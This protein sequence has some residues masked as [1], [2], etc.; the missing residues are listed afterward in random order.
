[1]ESRLVGASDHD[2]LTGKVRWWANGGGFM[3]L[4]LYDES[5]V[6]P[7]LMSIIA[8]SH[9][10]GTFGLLTPDTLLI[11]FYS[12]SAKGLATAHA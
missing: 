10:I 11:G 5:I 2:R 6:V 1:M 3:G 12:W 8:K 7:S 9:P 4:Y